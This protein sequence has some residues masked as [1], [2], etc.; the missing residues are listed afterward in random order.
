MAIT[1]EQKAALE[2]PLNRANVKQRT[3]AGRTL[4]YVEGWHAIAEA[5]RIFGFDDWWRETVDMRE[6]RQPELV[7]GKWR[8][9]YLAKVRVQALGVIREGTGYGSGI[10]KDLGDAIESA[11]KEA[12]TD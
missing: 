3:Q 7:D 12:E 1:D 11:I 9:G 2:G 10:A 5:N 4:D 8:V 6:V